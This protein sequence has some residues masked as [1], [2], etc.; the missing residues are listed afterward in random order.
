MDYIVFKNNRALYRQEKFGG[1]VY[2]K[3][4]LFLLNQPQYNFINSF[5]TYK[6]FNQLNDEE[7]E[8]VND[9]LKWEIF[10]K[11]KYS[12]AMRIIDKKRN[13]NLG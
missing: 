6:H 9:F 2:Y 12:N 3:S 4:R 10:L 5:D 8:Y 13:K 11:L 7:K 1:I